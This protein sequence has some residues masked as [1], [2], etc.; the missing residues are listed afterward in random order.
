[1]SEENEADYKSVNKRKWLHIF[2]PPNDHSSRVNL[3][4]NTEWLD[5]SGSVG[6]GFL[7]INSQ[8]H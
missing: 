6:Y 7:I 8:N 3:E 4:L 5:I 2:S 1:M